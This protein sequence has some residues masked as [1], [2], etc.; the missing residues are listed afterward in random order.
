[1]HY[2]NK[3]FWANHRVWFGEWMLAD[4]ARHIR[5]V[6]NIIRCCFYPVVNIGCAQCGFPSP[7]D[8]FGVPP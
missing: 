4:Y 8:N 3:N 1:M 2:F 6:F 5:K 7:V